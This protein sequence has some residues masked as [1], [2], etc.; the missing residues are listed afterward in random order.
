MTTFRATDD[1][2]SHTYSVL[3]G[4]GEQPATLSKWVQTGQ[5]TT[6]GDNDLEEVLSA[7]IA[8]NTSQGGLLSSLVTT[9]NA[10]D[11][12]VD[13][14]QALVGEQGDAITAL[15]EKDGRLDT[16]NTEQ[17]TAIS[18]LQ[19]KD[20]EQDADIDD[21]TDRINGVET[22]VQ[23]Q[24]RAFAAHQEIVVNEL[25]DPTIALAPEYAYLSRL[26]RPTQGFVGHQGPVEY[27]PGEYEHTTGDTANRMKVKFGSTTVDI[28]GSNRT[29]IGFMQRAVRLQHDDRAINDFGEVLHN[30]AGGAVPAFY[31]G[32]DPSNPSG[33]AASWQ[34]W[35]K[36]S[37]AQHATN[38]W[39][40]PTTVQ[41]SQFV[42]RVHYNGGANHVDIPMQMTITRTVDGIDYTRCNAG[43]NPQPG[44]AWVSA[45]D[46]TDADDSTVEIEFRSSG[47]DT[48]WLGGTTQG[49][50]WIDPSN[51]PTAVA[52]I[53]RI[54]RASMWQGPLLASLSRSG[55]GSL[56]EQSW[57]IPAGATDV[58]TSADTSDGSWSRYLYF[59]CDTYAQ[60]LSGSNG[61]IVAVERGGT[62]TSS[63]FIPWTLFSVDWAND[64]EFFAGKWENTGAG[65]TSDN[66]VLWA[67]CGVNANRLHLRLA[68]SHADGSSTVRVYRNN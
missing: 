26:W 13:A 18:A 20:L 22:D 16:K 14:V 41:S 55:T 43:A 27:S 23:N 33:L 57:T 5:T 34:C 40:L 15:Q 28:D 7:I 37:F 47:G 58:T 17:D 21:N 60:A 67:S 30:P 42:A 8:E 12:E 19:T 2:T 36:T 66:K 68:C 56:D 64:H 10:L 9:N 51:N 39:N 4:K 25:P 35:I 65:D 50:T 45:L 32:R 31:Y 11:T 63:V 1:D 53:D 44:H 38:P 46:L 62:I 48:L 61:I 3:A 29:M 24:I 54:Q 59:G 52:R 49:W 6:G